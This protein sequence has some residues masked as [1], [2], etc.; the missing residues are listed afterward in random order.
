MQRLIDIERPV[1]VCKASA[2]TGKTYTL[3]AY[4]VGLL[5]SGEDYRSI[6]AI[7]F[8]N[9]ATAEMN[10][11]IL[12]YLYALSRG[13]EKAFLDR[14]RA[15]MLRDADM[16]DA[17][18][19]RRAGVCFERM[20]ID[21]DN[22]HVMTIDAFLQ[23]LLSG[24]AGILQTSAGTSTEL[25]VKHVVKEA[26]DQLLTDDLT[27][28]VLRIIEQ[29]SHYKYT[30]ATSWDIRKDV[31]RLAENLYDEKAQLLD[32]EKKINFNAAFIAQRRKAIEAIWLKSPDVKRIEELL[33]R[34][35]AC[36]LTVKNGSAIVNAIKNIRT[37]IENPRSID[38]SSDRFRGLTDNQISAIEEGKWKEVPAAAQ[39]MILEA[40]R[41]IRQSK[42]LYNTLSLTNE[43]SHDLELMAPLQHIIQRNLTESNRALLAKTASV[44]SQALKEGD[45]DFILEKAGIRYHHI[46]MDEFQDTSRLQWEVIKRLLMDV[47]ASEGNTLLI[48]GDIKQSIYRWRNGDWHIMDGLSKELTKERINE[49]FTSLTKNFR[50]SEEV[51]RFN[52]SLFQHII[53]SYPQVISDADE[54]EQQLV[55]RIYGEGFTP[56]Q[57]DSFY[58]S[59]KKKGGYVC[60]RTFEPGERKADTQEMM[61]MEMFRTMEDLLHRGMNPS[62]MLILLRAKTVIP[63]ITRMHRELD[64]AEF[65]QLTK[66]PMV[67]ESS[68]LLGSSTAVTVVIAALRWIHDASD[69][70]AKH[71]IERFIDKPDIIGQIRGSVRKDT[72]LYEAVSELISLLLTN[73]EG[74][75]EG[76]QTAYINCLLDNTREFVHT[77]G[78]RI[79]DFLEYWEDTLKEQSI[80]SSSAGAIRIMSIHKSKGLQAQSVFIPFCD[81]A[82]ESP[83]DHLWCPIAEEL[84]QGE[85]HVPI[86]CGS[87]MADSA[88]KAAYEEELKSARV[89]S[90]NMLYVALTRAEDNLFIY[91]DKP[92]EKHVGRFI[93]DY[94][95]EMAPG[96]ENYETGAIRI[97]SGAKKVKKEETKPFAFDDTEI[98]EEAEL[99]TNSNQVRF[100]QSQEGALY[101][102]YGEEAYRR[103]ARMEE[104]ILCHDIFAHLRKADELEGVLDDF[105]SRGMIHDTAQREDIK[106][107]ISSAWEGSA[108]MRDWF[109]SPW[110]LHLEEPIYIEKKELRPD[111]VMINPNTKEAIVLDYK[112]GHW[113]KTYIDQVRGYMHALRELGY[114]PVRGYLWFARENKLVEVKNG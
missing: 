91:T 22:V 52:L 35:E 1:T 42:T 44:L 26:V 63:L 57:I 30:Q 60:F 70:V 109:T 103:T 61:I 23:S 16:P 28:E 13:E 73:E 111:R 20:L 56:D 94:I 37:S 90:L 77:Y 10:E 65:P 96:A 33:S 102:E 55:A 47:L 40:T 88:Y 68:F 48:V 85:D 25:D 106:T 19:A 31:C 4:Y 78:S 113:E 5:L 59:D 45:A 54:E 9:K 105:E 112:F 50:S 101:T 108:E 53:D 24:L 58:Q 27:D 18:L 21:F 67:S 29:Y 41:L 81:W 72:P 79:D 32:N 98:V 114:A 95:E 99:W 51:V 93:T 83:E 89:D 62:D 43:R 107:L 104:G 49:Q 76:S 66:V 82:I 87:A 110:Q 74:C 34:L 6:L 11:R 92:I 7:T 46:L 69:E 86:S 17:E 84:A 2:G 100:V 12:T 3:A 39:E 97:A 8:T 15:F 38:K 14:A 75:Y 80:P 64:P 36:D 71:Q